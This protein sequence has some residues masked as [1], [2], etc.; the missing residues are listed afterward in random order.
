MGGGALLPRPTGTARR[1]RKKADRQFHIVPELA[2]QFL[3]SLSGPGSQADPDWRRPDHQVGTE[4]GIARQH[5][6]LLI[7]QP[8]EDWL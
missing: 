7:A 6:G 8:G 3:S 2:V 5:A 4:R 1:I